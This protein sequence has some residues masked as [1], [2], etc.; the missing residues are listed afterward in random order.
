MKNNFVIFTVVSLL[1]FSCKKDVKNIEVK[2]DSIEIVAD[3]KVVDGHNSQNALDWQGTYKG[4]LPC[5]DCEGI[6][7]TLTLNDDNT[8]SY[9]T[10]Y[11]GKEG[12]KVFEQKGIFSWN[13]TGSII[14]LSDLEG[15]PYLYKVGEN[16]LTQ[17]DLDG[18]PITGKLAQMYILKK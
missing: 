12:N 7:T 6:V 17:L 14:S 18:Y 15:K 11:L 9:K 10:K 13:E 8:Y 16:T 4:I 5:A 2:T 3:S 1:L